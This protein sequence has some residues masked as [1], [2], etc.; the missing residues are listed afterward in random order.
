[1]PIVAGERPK[2]KKYNAKLYGPQIIGE[3]TL[4][5]IY[6]FLTDP[7]VPRINKIEVGKPFALKLMPDKIEQVNFNFS[8]SDETAKVLIDLFSRET[9][10]D[11]QIPDVEPVKVI[12]PV[13]AQNQPPLE[14]PATESTTSNPVYIE[15]P[16]PPSDSQSH[17][18]VL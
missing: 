18:N 7:E 8:L 13:P 2:K 16:T 9:S 11:A 17:G 1:M 12:N 5:E 14:R 4:R 3:Y 15:A 6:L 10:R